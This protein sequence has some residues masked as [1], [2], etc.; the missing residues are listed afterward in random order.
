M[1]SSIARKN[2]LI[3]YRAIPHGVYSTDNRIKRQAINSPIEWQTE[4]CEQQH[5]GESDKHFAERMAARVLQCSMKDNGTAWNTTPEYEF[6][7]LHADE[8]RWDRLD[9]QIRESAKFDSG[10]Y[11][12]VPWSTQPYASNVHCLHFPHLSVKQPGKMAFTQTEAHG[13]ADRQTIISPGKYLFRYFAPWLNQ[14]TVDAYCASI[15]MTMKFMAAPL[16]LAQTSDEIVHVYRS[17]PSSCMSK[18]RNHEEYSTGG[19]HPV[20]V[21][22]AGDLAVA[23]FTVEG[24]IKARAI[25]WPAKKIYG[26]MYGDEQRLR[27]LLHRDGF[28]PSS[29]RSDWDGAKL[30]KVPV[31]DGSGYVCPYLDIGNQHVDVG[32]THLLVNQDGEYAADNVSS[33][34]AGDRCSRDEDN[35]GYSCE[36]C[37][38]YVNEG[39]HFNGP[40][41]NGIYCENCFRE[42]FFYCERCETDITRDEHN[43]VH[44]ARR[45]VLSVCDSCLADYGHRCGYCEEYFAIN[46]ARRST[47]NVELAKTVYGP[48]E[49]GFCPSCVDDEHIEKRACG[50]YA[51]KTENC[52]C[53]C[54]APKIIP[55]VKTVIRAHKA[56]ASL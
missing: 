53:F 10:L 1:P 47:I 44:T 33:V 49:D 34:I 4:S 31:P 11:Q 41:G 26:R 14:A 38:D 18:D 46:W 36:H 30:L 2:A 48:D 8:Y 12:Q 7:L 21:Y 42:L 24:V 13:E 51:P 45:G 35:D 29:S 22:G 23:Y 16:G 32:K 27:L 6:K 40:D 19:I 9:W 28:K 50:H 15:D 39:D 52:V 3:V 55:I 20:S 5:M 56:G 17:G 54:G 43:T 37:N 25:C